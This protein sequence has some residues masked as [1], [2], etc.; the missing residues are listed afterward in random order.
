M[1]AKKNLATLVGDK[2]KKFVEVNSCVKKM[3]PEK[4]PFRRSVQGCQMA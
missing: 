3:A 2:Q 1:Y 4:D